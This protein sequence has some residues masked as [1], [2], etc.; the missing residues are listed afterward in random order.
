MI[1]IKP[2]RLSGAVLSA[3][4]SAALLASCS[5]LPSVPGLTSVSPYRIEIQQGNFLS[6]EMVSQLKPGMSKDQVRFV[7]GTPLVTDIFHGDRWDYVYYRETSPGKGEQ[8][9]LSV[10]F[11][12][13]VLARLSGDVVPAGDTPAAPA[14]PGAAPAPAE[15]RN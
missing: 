8:R 2:L 11:E 14:A 6:Q 3:A 13:E 15:R 7:L 4:L 10:F 1:C 5:Y 9:R 12:N